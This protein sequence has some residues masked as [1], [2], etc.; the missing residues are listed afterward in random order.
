MR[1]HF[2]AGVYH[3]RRLPLGG[4]LSPEVTDEGA[5]GL[6][7]GAE[8][9]FRWGDSWEP[10]S[11]LQ[12]KVGYRI[13]PSSAPVCA[14]GH[15]P[16]KGKAL[17]RWE[18]SEA[19]VGLFRAPCLSPDLESFFHKNAFQ[20]I[21]LENTSQIGLSIPEE[22]EPRTGQ[23]QPSPNPASGNERP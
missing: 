16:P 15:L 12:G 4:K 13:A 10:P 18:R 8:E 11:F 9:N 2:V 22:I 1:K 7:N 23:R 19:V 3:L 6:P 14:L 20:H 21:F 17:G 5:T